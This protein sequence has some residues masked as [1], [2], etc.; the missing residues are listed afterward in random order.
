MKVLKAYKT[1]ENFDVIITPFL[2]DNF[3]E[4]R[5][6]FVFKKLDAC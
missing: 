2:F 6:E 3:I 1:D 5:I 4:K